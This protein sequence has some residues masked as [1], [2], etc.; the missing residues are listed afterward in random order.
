MT[1]TAGRDAPPACAHCG[2][3]VLAGSAGGARFCCAGCQAA[4]ALIR[5][6][7]LG[8]YYARRQLDPTQRP[9]KPPEN[10]ATVDW[11]AFER[12]HGDVVTVHA[13]IDGLHCGA[14]VW[15]IE[16]ALGRM[17][18]VVAARVNMTTRRLRL[19]WR[20]GQTDATTLAAR[21]FELG[22][23]LVPYD[24]EA[25]ANADHSHQQFL[26]RCLAVAGFAAG[27]IMLLS[28]AVWAGAASDMRPVTRDLMHWISAAIAIPAIAYAGRPFF[29][30]ALAALRAGHTNMDVPISLAVVL[31]ALVSVGQTASHAD[32]AYFDAAVGLLFF[33]LIG[34]TLEHRARGQARHAAEQLLSLQATAA[35]RIDSQG[36]AVQTAI[37]RLN[38]GD[39]VQ[40]T[41]G[42]RV[43][44][45]GTVIDGRSDF[46]CALVTG[47][48]TPVAAGPG[49]HVF[50]GTV[51]VTAPVRLRVTA[52]GDDTVLGGIVRLMETAEQ[53]RSRFAQLADRVSRVYVPVVHGLALVTFAGWLLLGAV[54]WQTALLHAV[55]VLIV[56]CPCALALAVPVVQV[57]ASGRLFADGILLTSGT[58][59][60]RLA[61]A[62]MVVFDKTGTLTLG[63]PRLRAGS[64][65]DR[66]SLKLAASL[67]AAS[68]HPLARALAAT[69]PNVAVAKG[70]SEQPGAGLI[71]HAP[72]GPV[73]LGSRAWIGDDPH[74][75]ASDAGADGPELWL[76]VPGKTPIRF[77]FDDPLR[78]DAAAS[79]ASLRHLGFTVALRSG[80][81][82]PVVKSVAA[83]L[84]IG[85]WR[86]DCRPADKVAALEA[87]RLAGRRVVMVGD[88]LNDA[89]ALA[90]AWASMSPAT[91]ADIS[92][93]AADVVFMGDRLAPVTT[94][95]ATARRA[96]RVMRQNV[97]L[98][99]VY[100]LFAVPLAIAGL[101]TP[102]WAAIAMS[103]SSLIVT[104]NALRLSRERGATVRK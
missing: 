84:A 16:T 54:H 21:V 89:P 5:G 69:L 27:N 25:L 40:L 50:A 28:V 7:G 103:S 101:I 4:D 8:N 71:A 100:N 79:I 12:R 36:R 48:S 57:A 86:G 18:G 9:P 76:A 44:V 53:D 38:E 74:G 46:D 11:A 64:A 78:P 102:L 82:D 6:L 31:A 90:A 62:D 24:L 91:A 13:M 83:A 58:A 52:V 51:N 73:R 42:E 85:D 88:G 22:Y 49:E 39:L 30:A 55:A 60:E 34:R 63:R 81:R 92:R 98:A 10:D 72:Q 68:R 20:A 96:Y 67:A 87:W 43:P 94:A 77:V 41:A 19:A 104:L 17:P 61:R 23:R 66:E 37:T 80:D 93:A 99:V 33:L 75:N 47:E 95:L 3:P 14:C 56:T 45:D 35:T 70:V 15:L 97:G 32:H 26:L 2:Q 59:L 29:R 1:A 65:H